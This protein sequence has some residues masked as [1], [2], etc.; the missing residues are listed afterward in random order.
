MHCAKW[1]HLS[2]PF[3]GFQGRGY[4]NHVFALRAAIGTADGP[5]SRAGHFSVGGAGG[6][7][8]GVLGFTLGDAFR[9]FPI[10]GRPAGALRGDKAW[11]ASAEW[12]FPVAM[13]HAGAGSWPLHVDRIA[14]SLFVDVGGAGREAEGPGTEWRTLS[15][16][17]AELVVVGS[18]LFEAVD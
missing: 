13:V 11:S 7:G 18:L 2:T 4:S 16:L 6:D 17:G 10:R 9:R 14:G 3:G 5:G 12:R 8:R 1:S 15:S